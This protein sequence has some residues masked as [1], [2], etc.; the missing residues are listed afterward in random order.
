MGI[1]QCVCVCVDSDGGGWPHLLLEVSQGCLA[2]GPLPD[3]PSKAA[4]LLP[5]VVVSPPP[6]R[7][8]TPG[9][10]LPF[11]PHHSPPFVLLFW[12]GVGEEAP[13]GQTAAGPAPGTA[14]LPGGCSQTLL[15]APA[16]LPLSPA[17]WRSL[18]RTRTPKP[19]CPAQARHWAAG[20]CQDSAGQQPQAH[21]RHGGTRDALEPSTAP[22]LLCNPSSGPP[23]VRT[24]VGG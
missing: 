7:S 12:R 8:H 19:P 16:L 18:P 10:Q 6:P 11:L 23:G 2:D 14:L 5:T 24:W 21:A 1:P 15:C 3:P 9:Q 17:S 4:A 20:A 13:G 22:I